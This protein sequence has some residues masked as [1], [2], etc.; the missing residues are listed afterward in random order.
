MVD[1]AYGGIQSSAIGDTIVTQGVSVSDIRLTKCNRPWSQA[2]P[3]VAFKAIW[4]GNIKIG[5]I[6]TSLAS[7]TLQSP[8]LKGV[9]CETT[10]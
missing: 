5:T 2:E 8:R 1:Y 4:H 3:G 10:S 9:A 7:H 6:V